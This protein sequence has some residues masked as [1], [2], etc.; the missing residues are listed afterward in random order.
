[1]IDK[2]PSR[3]HLKLTKISEQEAASFPAAIDIVFYKDEKERAYRLRYADNLK[4][5]PDPIESLHRVMCV[6]KYAPEIIEGEII[7]DNSDEVRIIADSDLYVLQKNA[8]KFEFLDA[9]LLLT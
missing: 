7:G 6:S 1:M 5:Y 3:G 8:E 9:L 2:Y 4:R